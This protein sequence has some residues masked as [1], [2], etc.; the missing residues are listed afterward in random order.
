[1]TQLF[2]IIQEHPISLAIIGFGLLSI[3][4]IVIGIV[5]IAFTKGEHPASNLVAMGIVSLLITLIAGLV[6]VV[7]FGNY[8]GFDTGS[9][10][11]STINNV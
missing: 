1:M 8:S 10:T 4:A 9:E 7:A 3:V 2:A 6:L 5:T 11:I